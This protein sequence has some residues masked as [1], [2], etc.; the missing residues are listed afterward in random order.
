MRALSLSQ[1]SICLSSLPLYSFRILLAQKSVEPTVSFTKL[2]GA[3]GAD[4]T[5]HET[6][7]SISMTA[8]TCQS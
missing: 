2:V 1:K 5:T 8:L 3:G 7:W 4:M 6:D